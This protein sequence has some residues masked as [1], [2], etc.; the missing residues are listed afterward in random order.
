MRRF[1]NAAGYVLTAFGFVLLFG[2][3]F[4]AYAGSVA[5]LNVHGDGMAAMLAVMW[6]VSAAFVVGFSEPP[7]SPKPD[8]EE[9][10]RKAR[11]AAMVTEDRAASQLLFQLADAVR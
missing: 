1:I 11:A 2:A 4:N 5:G 8:V 3:L 10:R 6:I 7:P 9:L